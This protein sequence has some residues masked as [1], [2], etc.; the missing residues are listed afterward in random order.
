MTGR[1]MSVTPGQ[2]MGAIATGAYHDLWTDGAG[3]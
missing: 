3:A 2:R 1:V